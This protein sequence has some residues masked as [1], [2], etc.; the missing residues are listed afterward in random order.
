MAFP[1]LA[2]DLPP[3][4]RHAIDSLRYLGKT[5]MTDVFVLFGSEVQGNVETA[6]WLKQVKRG[7]DDKQ[8][9]SDI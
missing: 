5:A 2:G 4:C 3:A 8:D 9:L 6:G 7:N 1:G